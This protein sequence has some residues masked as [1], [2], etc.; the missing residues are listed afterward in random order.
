MSLQAMSEA[1]AINTMS[2]EGTVSLRS[3]L[4]AHNKQLPRFTSSMKW[5]LEAE[6][7]FCSLVRKAIHFDWCVPRYLVSTLLRLNP[8]PGT[9]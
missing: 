2:A 1:R 4:R 8:W 3:R 6:K 9:T 5:W 7:D